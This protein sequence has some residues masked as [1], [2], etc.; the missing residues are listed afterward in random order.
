MDS[1]SVRGVPDRIGILN[2]ITVAIEFKRSIVDVLN[3]SESFPLQKFTLEQ[4]E[5]AGGIGLFLFP[6]N[7]EQVFERLRRSCYDV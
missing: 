7:K 5:K 1:Q 3:P 6:E 2:G 4:I